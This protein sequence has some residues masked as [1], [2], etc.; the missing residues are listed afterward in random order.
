MYFNQCLLAKLLCFLPLF[1]LNAQDLPSR[2]DAAGFPFARN[3]AL[4]GA[5]TGLDGDFSS[6][7]TNPAALVG[8]ATR[9]NYME[10]AVDTID[11][12]LV[13]RLIATDDPLPAF[14]GFLVDNFLAGVDLGGPFAFGRTGD[15]YAVGFFNVSK[16][17]IAWDRDQVYMVL[18]TLTEEFTLAGAYGLRLYNGPDAN[19][20]I[21]ITAKVFLRMGY[22]SRPI[23]LQQVKYIL[24]DL[25]EMPF[26]T[27]LGAGAD[28]GF[29]WT[30]NETLSFAAVIYDPF[31]PV[32]VTQYSTVGKIAEQEMIAEATIPVTTRASI[33]ISW[34]LLPPDSLLH[35]YFSDITLSFDYLGLL[36]NLSETPRDPLLNI[37]A[38]CEIRLLE[39][40][41]LRA[42]FRD[43]QPS[44]G[45][46][47]NFTFMN[48]DVSIYGSELSDK[49]YHYSTW[50][51]AVNISFRGS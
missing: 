3:A 44:G 11:V 21:G 6:I 14:S 35:K 5:H 13:Y 41:S 43:M 25:M 4:G 26:E 27:Q 9:K 38:G 37:S 46:G 24:Q 42:G 45:I 20:D 8:A 34:K 10:F 48:L 36:E 23:Y 1:A 50:S 17:N 33:G 51:A 12:E 32:L 31:S 15:G 2:V 19:F 29:R 22:R 7:F 39:V 18:P 49:P 30:L 16:L 47:L 28:I 40:L